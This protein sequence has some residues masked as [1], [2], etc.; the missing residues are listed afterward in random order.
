[1]K[2]ILLSL[3][4]AVFATNSFAQHDRDYKKMVINKNVF[5][6]KTRDLTDDSV[7]LK[8]YR[9]ERLIMTETLYSGGLRELK[10]PDFNKD[11]YSDIMLEYIG[12][13]PTYQLY[14]FDPKRNVFKRLEGFDKFPASKQ[15]K[16][17]SRFYY[18]YSRAGCADMNWESDLFKIENFKT[19]FL[20]HI[21]GQGCD[22]DIQENP[23]KIEVYKVLEQKEASK[24]L[25]E[26]LPY[27]TNIP[28]FE[29]KW[30][31]IETYWKNNYTKF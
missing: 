12:N 29:D 4:V 16:P 11:G 14:L 3:L 18:S 2:T 17:E 6:I 23:Q 9:N 10:F 27:L 20:A 8:V 13:N 28:R 22:F 25:I 15:V 31:F 1:M 30:K 5:F 7:L 19:I 26:T 21:D 24:K